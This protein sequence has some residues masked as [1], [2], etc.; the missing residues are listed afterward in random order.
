MLPVVSFLAL[1]T[2]LEPMMFAPSG[3]SSSLYVPATF[4]VVNSSLM[5][6]SQS[7]QSSLHFALASMQGSSALALAVSATS[8][9]LRPSNALHNIGAPSTMAHTPPDSSMSSSSCSSAGVNSGI[10]ESDG[11]SGGTLHSGCI[12]CTACCLQTMREGKQVCVEHLGCIGST[13]C[14]SGWFVCTGIGAV[15]LW[16]ALG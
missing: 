13:V 4:K 9:Y 15:M 8:M 14:C 7:S 3:A 10:L 11:A 2:H 6:F 12:A 5:A 16:G 1:K